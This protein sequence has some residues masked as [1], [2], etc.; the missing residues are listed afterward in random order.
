[1]HTRTLLIASFLIV[2]VPLACIPRYMAMEREL[3]DEEKIKILANEL[4]QTQAELK[5]SNTVRKGNY[6]DLNDLQVQYAILKNINAQ[7]A[8]ENKTLKQ[9]LNK[10]KSVIHLQGKVIRLL[11]DTKQTIETSLKDQI[12]AQEIEVVEKEDTLRVIFIDKILFDS[13]SVEINPKGK[14]LLLIMAASLKDNKNHD[15]VVEGHTDDIPLGP[16]LRKRFPSN[17]ELSTARAAA[18][19]QIFQDEGGIPP[20]RLSVRGFSSYRPV[21]SNQTEEGRRQNRRIEIILS[22]SK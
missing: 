6:K 5:H 12:A 4:K 13:G 20:K 17:W 1:M 21:A 15:V 16:L 2:M 11:D 22:P 19:A 3:E 8:E 14:E 9:E 18:V 7:M 10:K